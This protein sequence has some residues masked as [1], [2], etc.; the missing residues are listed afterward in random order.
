MS[1][2]F[3]REDADWNLRARCT[4]DTLTRKVSVWRDTRR[5]VGIHAPVGTHSVARL[6]MDRPERAQRSRKAKRGVLFAEVSRVARGD[7]KGH[8]GGCVG[9]ASAG[10]CECVGFLA[11]ARLTRRSSGTE[12][13]GDKTILR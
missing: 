10:A 7:G 8:L 3:R 5:S 9:C 12:I 2:S 1:F 13:E 6:G 11:R 4:R